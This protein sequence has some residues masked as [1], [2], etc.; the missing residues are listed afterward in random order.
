[1]IPKGLLFPVIA[2]TVALFFAAFCLWVSVWEKPSAEFRAVLLT[3]WTIG[4]PAYFFGEYLYLSGYGDLGSFDTL[5]TAPEPKKTWEW[6]DEEQFS[7]RKKQHV[8]KIKA[9]FKKT[10]EVYKET[11]DLGRNFWLAFASLLLTLYFGKDVV[12]SLSGTSFIDSHVATLRSQ[13]EKFEADVTKLKE[14]AATLKPEDRSAQIN[15]LRS[16]S[17]ILAAHSANIDA[18]LDALKGFPE[19]PVT[20]STKDSASASKQ[21]ISSAEASL[22]GVESMKE[23]TPVKDDKE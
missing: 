20:P 13:A 15:R 8:D 3:C 12:K 18:L 14:T 4:V 17:V 6:E 11:R 22:T 21:M 23:V 9:D 10:Y 19:A 5:I 1:M 7:N 16:E 2:T